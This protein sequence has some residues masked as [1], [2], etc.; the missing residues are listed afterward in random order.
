MRKYRIAVLVLFALVA[1]LATVAAAGSSKDEL[2]G[3]LKGKTI[4][5]YTVRDWSP[6][7]KS[8]ELSST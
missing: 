3:N 1:G 7:P 8:G 5:G 6:N 4:E 2:N